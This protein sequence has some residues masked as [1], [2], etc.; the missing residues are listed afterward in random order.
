M[1][2]GEIVFSKK[3]GPIA[4]VESVLNPSDSLTAVLTPRWATHGVPSDVNSHPPLSND[5]KIA[6]VHNGTIDNYL[7]IKSSLVNEG[8]NFLSESD[9]EVY[10][11]F[12]IEILWRD[13]VKAVSK[14][15]VRLKEYTCYS[16]STC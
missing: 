9:T 1:H 8:F 16:S 4:N 7:D 12:I 2:E 3:E 13:L 10:T 5:G 15:L 14:I 11:K 6:V